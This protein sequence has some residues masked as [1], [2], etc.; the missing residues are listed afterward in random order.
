[1]KKIKCILKDTLSYIAARRLLRYSIIVIIILSLIGG[2]AT[3]KY[4]N[5]KNY[6]KEKI[7]EQSSNVSNGNKDLANGNINTNAVLDKEISKHTLKEGFSTL[8]DDKSPNSNTTNNNNK[9]DTSQNTS[10]SSSASIDKSSIKGIDLEILEGYEFNAK[11]DLKL[12]ATDKDGSDISDSIIL[13][14]NNVNT[15]VPGIYTVKASVRLSNG[16]YKEKEFT[17]TVKETRLDVSLLTFKPIKSNVKKGEKIGFDLNLNI[18][19]KH[20]TP[21]AVMINGQEY[22]LYNGNNNIIDKL[23]NNKNYK[24]FI[25]EKDISGVYEYNLEHIKLSNGSWISLGENIQTIEVLKDQAFI[26]NFSYEEL[27]LEK[28]INIKFELNDLENTSSNLRLEFYNKNEKL[29]DIKLDKKNNYSMYLPIDRNGE[30]HL[31]ILGD[32][33]LNQNSNDGNTIYNKEIYSTNINIS[34]IN[35][36]SITGEN[37]ELTQGD[38]FDLIKDLNLKAIDFD[39]E[40]ITDKIQIESNNVDTNIVGRQTV[41]VSIVNKKGEKYAK[42]FYVTINLK[43]EDENNLSRMLFKNFSKNKTKKTSLVSLSNESDIAVSSLS[44]ESIVGNDTQ[45][46]SHIVDIKGSVSKYDG[47]LPGGK[48]QVEVPTAMSFIV[49]QDGNFDSANYTINNRSSVGISVSVSEFRDSDKG[50]GITV[51]PKTEDI[52]TLD[53]S[54]LHLELVGNE[55]RSIDLGKKIIN[56]QEILRLDPASSSIIQLSGEV[57]KGNGES[58]DKDGASEKFTLIFRINKI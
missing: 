24:V 12:Q 1:M 30:Y 9:N 6:N 26:N 43:D 50:G 14:R 51:K 42:E 25:D 53:R 17:V 16:E 29:K 23:F 45:V 34:N 46:L 27:S 22:T 40:D 10:S 48:I 57:G 44:S 33:S 41:V 19:K 5:N 15:I 39:G 49:D 4:F 32:I 28:K 38:N 58:V 31:K 21:I 47:S 55:G 56:P 2:I 18:S 11:R 20:I 35:Q 13:E 7:E 37:L 8:N 3:N 54:N 36:T 52:S